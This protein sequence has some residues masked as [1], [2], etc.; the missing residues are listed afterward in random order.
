MV[1]LDDLNRYTE[2]DTIDFDWI[3]EFAEYLN[4]SSADHIYQLGS[5]ANLTFLFGK[6]ALQRFLGVI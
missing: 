4:S 6:L 3:F 2:A 5:L 1:Y